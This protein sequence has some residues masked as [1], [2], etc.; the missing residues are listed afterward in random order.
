MKSTT[1]LFAVRAPLRKTSFGAII[2]AML[3]IAHLNLHA[4]ET[5]IVGQPRHAGD[6]ATIRS[7]EDQSGRAVATRDYATLERIWSEHFVLNAPN[8]R[9]L[10]SRAA[11]FSVFKQSKVDLYSSYEKTIECIAFDSDVVVVMGFETVT[12]AEGPGAGKPAQRR[13]TNVWRF[14]GGTWRLFARQ[15]TFPALN[16][17]MPEL[18]KGS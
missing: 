1:V 5:V 6:E 2:T 10:S 3:F 17:S 11:V 8:N 18:P 13:Y 15:A 12:P 9:I 16:A 7:L 4:G 14:V